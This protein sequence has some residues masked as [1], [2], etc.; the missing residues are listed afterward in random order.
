MKWNR[1]FMCTKERRNQKLN[2]Q[3]KGPKAG[4]GEDLLRTS[5][6]NTCSPSISW[7]WW[8][9]V[10]R[11]CRWHLEWLKSGEGLPCQKDLT[12]SASYRDRWL[13]R[14]FSRDR[15]RSNNHWANFPG[16]TPRLLWIQSGVGYQ[17][18]RILFEGQWPR[19]GLLLQGPWD[20]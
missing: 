7:Q 17:L 20:Q 8:G 6:L 14:P 3:R 16:L 13:L 19:W 11:G 9:R 2:A 15:T 10:S 4:R 12:N 18:E 5:S 1:N